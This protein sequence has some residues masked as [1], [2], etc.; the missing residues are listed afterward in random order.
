MS[1]FQGQQPGIF[2]KMSRRVI[3]F[4]LGCVAKHKL[5]MLL[6][7]WK[8]DGHPDSLWLYCFFCFLFLIKWWKKNKTKQNKNKNSNNKT[9]TKKKKKKESMVLTR[10]EYLCYFWAFLC[11]ILGISL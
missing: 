6:E 11:L 1:M 2:I 7:T 3:K 9:K 4:P 5:E 10:A 8:A